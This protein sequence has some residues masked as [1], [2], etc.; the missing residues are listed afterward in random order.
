ME[1]DERPRKYPK[2]NHDEAQEEPEPVMTGAVG[3]VRD[4]DAESADADS[5]ASMSDNG[6]ENDAEQAGVEEGQEADGKEAPPAMSKNQLKKLKR[7]EHW[8]AM[9]EQRKVK[10][11]E[12]LVAKRERRRAALEQAKQESAEATEE[13]RKTF[14]PTQKKF[15]RSTLLPVTLVL[16]C[17]YD[18]LMLDK[19]RVSLGAQITRSYSDNSRAPF[20]SHLVVSSFN[21]LLKERFDT[22]LGKTHENWK[23][24][25]FLQEDFAEAAEMAKGWMQGPKGGQLAGIFADKADAKPEDGEIVYL[26]SDSPNILTELKPYSTYIIGG[27]VDKNRHKGICYK[28]AVAKGIKTAKL[29]IGEYIQMAHRQVLA[30]NHVVEIMIRWLELGDWGKAFIQV[31]PQRKG[32]K[33][34]SADHESEDQ[35]PRE[36]VEAVEAGPD[37]EDA[38]EEAGEAG[39]A[40]K[41]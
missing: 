29:P 36:S 24:I 39:E 35:T 28:S 13:T 30:T 33:L 1:D 32:G 20:R 26:S 3:A 11:K 34:K 2:L 10:R 37:G 38:A 25:R 4:N 41:E 9:R 31:I 19:E 15:Q 21:K 23:G 14:E 5:H 22:V 8:E 7:K 40:G 17:S 16:D 18:D 6:N 27:L 12:K